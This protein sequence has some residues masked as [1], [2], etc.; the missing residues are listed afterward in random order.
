[1]ISARFS[2]APWLRDSETPTRCPDSYD[3]APLL[4]PTLPPNLAHST[5]SQFSTEPPIFAT[6]R[7]SRLKFKTCRSFTRNSIPRISTPDLN[8]SRSWIP[9]KCWPSRGLWQQMC[10]SLKP[11][12][13]AFEKLNCSAVYF[14]KV[15]VS[16]LSLHFESAWLFVLTGQLTIKS[17]ATSKCWSSGMI[18][19]CLSHLRF[20]WEL[21]SP[22]TQRAH[23]A[24]Q[25]IATS[26]ILAQPLQNICH[27]KYC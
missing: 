10:W 13:H 5:E 25:F 11:D 3:L 9:R 1:M 26:N 4:P 6:T 14:V 7:I 12:Q 8:L 24:S 20:C 15:C 19:V 16:L 2:S 22:N 17:S 21:F 18:L 27:E 23:S